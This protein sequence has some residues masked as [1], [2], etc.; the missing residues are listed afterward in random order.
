MII[1]RDLFTVGRKGLLLL[2]MIFISAMGVVLATHLS[3]QAITLKDQ[4]LTERERL[5]S[6]WRNLMLEETALAEHSRVQ[7][8]AQEELKMQRPASDKEVVLTL[9]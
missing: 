2:L 9:K 8:L 6:E 5:D 7:A 4:T 1:L 3:R